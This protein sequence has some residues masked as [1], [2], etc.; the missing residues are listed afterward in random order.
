MRLIA[1][2]AAFSILIG[3][4]FAEDVPKADLFL[5]YSFVRANSARDIPA[6]TND[7]GLGTFGWNFNKHIGAEFEFGGYHNGSIQNLQFDTTEMTYLFGPRVSLS[8]SRKVIP[9]VHTL[10]G[11]VHLTSSLPVTVAPT[12]FSTTTTTSRIA[13]S[14]DAFAMALGGGLDIRVSH[15]V[16]LRPVQFDYLMTRLEDFGQS[17]QPSQNRNQHNLR[18]GG[19]IMF[20]FGGE[21]PSPPPLPPPP[22]APAPLKQCTGGAAVPMNQDCPRQEA[23]F[24]ILA[25]PPRVC[26][27]TTAMVMADAP[28]PS[29]AVAQW[30]IN[31]EP[32]SQGQQLEFGSAGRDPGAYTI[33]LRIT[34]DGYNDATAD[35]TITVLGYMPP[36]GK[37]VV[38]PSEIWFGDKAT[39]SASFMPGQCG[40]ALGPVSFSAPEGAVGGDQFD[41]TGVQFAPPGASE[42]QKTITIMA[43]VSDEKG[44]AS[45][46]VDVVVKQRALLSA[47]QLPDVLFA[48]DS[49][50]VNNCGKRVLLEELRT[51]ENDDPAGKVVLVGH[52][53]DGEQVSKDL[54]LKRALNAAAVISAGREVCTAFPTSQIFVSAAGA[55]DNG[56]R[57]QPN[58]C[59]GSTA[60]SEKPGQAVA[61]GDDAAKYRRVE[62]WFVPTGGA[63]PSSGAGGKD[64]AALGV[65]RLGCPK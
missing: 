51:L 9:Y 19:G 32:I 53:A 52:L 6:F 59:G 18:Y 38:S 24:G 12:P 17:G 23:K 21:R 34:A 40:G 20:T 2:L 65:N 33:S 62:V 54:D 5:G 3:I 56:V 55:A 7:G 46:P 60:V 45:A 42:Q 28:L 47:R 63:L 22:P 49:D 36:S 58:F 39:L 1:R 15:H 16:T 50:R 27:G 44:S 26:Q 43:K 30:M 29:G 4:A 10:F 25:N 31:G 14:Q 13:A 8:R 57:T 11:G 41:S 35:S 64:A 37:L 61:P 48:K